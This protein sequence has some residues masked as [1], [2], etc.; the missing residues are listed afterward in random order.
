VSGPQSEFYCNSA[1][2]FA[3]F[4]SKVAFL[5]YQF[6]CSIAHETKRF[7]LSA[8]K[9][10]EHLGFDH[11]AVRRAYKELV[12]K[13][14]FALIEQGYYSPNSYEPILNHDAWAKMNPGQCCEKTVF[15]WTNENDKLG[16]AL[17]A[18]TGGNIKPK[19]HIIKALRKMIKEFGRSEEDAVAEFKSWYPHQFHAPRYVMGHFLKHCRAQWER[20]KTGIA[21]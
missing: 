16:Q 13:G 12:K 3:R 19:T 4:K 9:V 14:W 11:K 17:W 2:H 21:A 1:W 6:A 10:A 8:E 5:V 18:S 15:A 20:A 7:Y